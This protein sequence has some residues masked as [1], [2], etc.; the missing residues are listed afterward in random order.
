MAGI[1]LDGLKQVGG[2]ISFISNKF[3]ELNLKEVSEIEGTLT[4][5]NNNELSKLGLPKLRRLGG[6]L[7]LG[8]NSQLGSIEAF[9]EL[10][11]VDG[12]LDIV[13]AFDEVK[14]PKLSDVSFTINIYIYINTLCRGKG[15]L[16]Y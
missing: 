10:E 1:N 6:A 7:S 3:S 9:P 15:L 8:H 16:A 4:I 5:T 11:E 2:D 14:L 13:G 12:T